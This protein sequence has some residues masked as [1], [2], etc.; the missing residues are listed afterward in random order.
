MSEDEDREYSV[1]VGNVGTT[2]T[3]ESYNKALREYEHYKTVS[4]SPTGGRAS[5]EP[6]E[7]WP[8]DGV[9]A[10]PLLEYNPDGDE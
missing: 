5:G 10:E 9:I 1:I 4:K 7:L 3:T 8:S 2:L 6:V